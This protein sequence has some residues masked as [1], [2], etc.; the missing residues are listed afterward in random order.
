M[1]NLEFFINLWTETILPTFSG[2]ISVFTTPFST[3]VN[4]NINIPILGWLIEQLVNLF[5][6]I[7]LLEF[8]LGSAVI[9]VIIVWVIKFFI[10]IFTGS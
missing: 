2:M 5:P 4:E 7:T 1:I 8:I 9:L 3:L 6:D 10:G